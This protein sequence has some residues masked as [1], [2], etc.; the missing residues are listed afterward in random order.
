M[1]GSAAYGDDTHPRFDI[2]TVFGFDGYLLTSSR[3]K[4]FEMGLQSKVGFAGKKACAEGN[5]RNLGIT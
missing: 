5:D 2:L 1:S 3:L 4:M